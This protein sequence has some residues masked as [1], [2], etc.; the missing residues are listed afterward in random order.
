MRFCLFVTAL[1]LWMHSNCQFHLS[2]LFKTSGLQKE[3]TN[4]LHSFSDKSLHFLSSKYSKLNATIDKQTQRMFVH[5]QKKERKLK[6][7][8]E[9]NDS[10]KAKDLFK[11][12]EKN[13]QTLQSK[14]ISSADASD[15][16]LLQDYIPAVD[17]M[18]TAMLFLQQKDVNLSTEKLAKVSGVSAQLQGVQDKLQKANTVELFVKERERQLKN[19]LQNSG[20]AKQLKSINKEAFYYSQ[21]LREYKDLLNNKEKLEQKILG[22][23][24]ES[25]LFQSFMQKNSSLSR[26]FPTPANYGTREALAGLQTRASVQ[27]SLQQRFGASAFTAASPSPT[28]AGGAGNNNYLQQQI[29]SAQSQLNILKDKMG[30]LGVSGGSTDITMPD[31]KPNSEHTKSFLKRIEYGMNVQSEKSHSI[32]PATSEVAFTAGY[33]VSDKSTIGI[34]A[35]Y[36]MGWGSGGIQHIKLSHEGIG[37]RSYVDIKA[38]GSF[39]LSGGYEMNYMQAFAKYQQLYD[40]NMWQRSGLIGI[41]KKYKVGK[42]ENNMQLLWDFL[43]CQQVPRAQAVKFRVGFSL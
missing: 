37:L 42:K 22:A 23:V 3:A 6:N 33:K 30:K 36:K 11:G 41:T 32:I 15:S 26:L 12:F 20:F 10:L 4:D 18:Q 29:Q 5:L 21:R 34:G 8:L 35:V 40:L 27:Q 38:K 1:C 13:Y 2:E 25:K 28:G 16:T 39:W 19:Q 17:S 24:R 7:K 14:W 9:R 43:S 31:F